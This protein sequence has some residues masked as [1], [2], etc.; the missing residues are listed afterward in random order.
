MYYVK[1]EYY[2]DYDDK[3]YT[4]HMMICAESYAEAVEKATKDYKWV[5]SL[6]VE[7]IQF[8]K[9]DVIYIPKD[10]VDAVVAE[11]NY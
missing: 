6:T 1:M 10:C 9:C 7:Q 4:Y 11:N 2:C 8:E 5:N 3:E